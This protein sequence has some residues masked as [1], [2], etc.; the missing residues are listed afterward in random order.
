M[1]SAHDGKGRSSVRVFVRN[2]SFFCLDA[3]FGSFGRVKSVGFDDVLVG[4]GI[5]RRIAGRTAGPRRG[6]S[7]ETRPQAPARGPGGGPGVP[8]AAKE[9]PHRAR[10]E[11]AAL[12]G[13]IAARKVPLGG[14]DP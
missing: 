10:E 13:S 8:T 2:S 14:A 6:L 4:L 7:P 9:G 12:V 11:G 1:E 5:A 3:F